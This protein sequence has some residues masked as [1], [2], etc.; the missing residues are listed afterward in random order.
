VGLTPEVEDPAMLPEQA[1]AILGDRVNRRNAPDHV[2]PTG[3]VDAVSS[4]DTIDAGH[5]RLR[6]A[7]QSADGLALSSVTHDHRFFGK[8]N[9]YQWVELLAG[10][11]GRHIAQLREIATQVN[12]A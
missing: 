5:A 8:L 1:K 4:L 12:A 9:V 10:H 3:N 6:D 11:E 2:Q 7:L